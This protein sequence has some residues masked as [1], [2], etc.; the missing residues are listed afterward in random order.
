MTRAHKVPA[1]REDLVKADNSEKAKDTAG[2]AR[3]VGELDHNALL[4]K[5]KK[6]CRR[7][8]DAGAGRSGQS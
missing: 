1:R 6:K 3:E 5:R 7:R 8:S 2:P 4:R